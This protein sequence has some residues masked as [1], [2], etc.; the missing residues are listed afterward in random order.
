[1]N[2]LFGDGRDWFFKKRFGMFIHWGLYAIP[3]WHEQ[4][5]WRG[6]MKRVE[7]EKLTVDFNPSNFNPHSWLDILESVGMEYLC[8]TTKHHDG[9]CLWDTKYTQY[10]VMNTPYKKDIIGQLSEA[11]H[12]RGIN[13]GFY[14]SLPDWHHPNYPNVGRHHEMFGPRI[15]DLPDESKYLAFVKNQVREL[16]TNYGEIHQFFWDVNVAEFNDPSLNRM[17]RKLQPNAVINDRGP[18]T[19]DYST[20]ERHIPSGKSFE[21]PT[22]AVQSLGRESWGYRKTEDYYTHRFLISSIDR[23]LAMGGNYL[24]NVGPKPDGTFPLKCI[25]TLELIGNWYNKV[26]ESFINTHPCSYLIQTETVGAGA[27]LFKYDEL[28]LTRNMNKI[29]VHCPFGLQTDSVVLNGFS[30]QPKTVVLLNNGKMLSA[31]V[32]T[33]PWR[34]TSLPCL[35]IRELPSNDFANETFVIKLEFD[36]KLMA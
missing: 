28:F 13:L 29:Y 3:A 27:K 22:E 20:P 11:C 30:L 7:Y 12:Q 34:W 8:I 6:N 33:L 4:I 31:K 17:I 21:E 18:S 2:R 32:D 23:V 36:E 35:Q 5:L 15:N 16:L 9:F 19:G 25:N 1:M 24:L 14:Y 10:N 26:K